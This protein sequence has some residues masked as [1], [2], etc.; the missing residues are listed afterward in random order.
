VIKVDWL[1]AGAFLRVGDVLL[2][3]FHLSLAYRLQNLPPN[4]K[5]KPVPEKI[6]ETLL[7]NKKQGQLRPWDATNIIKPIYR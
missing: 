5:Q 7:T 3:S 2:V 4:W 6:S 1:A